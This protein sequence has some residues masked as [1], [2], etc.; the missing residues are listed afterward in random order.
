[1]VDVKIIKIHDPEMT[2]FKERDTFSMDDSRSQ[3]DDDRNDDDD[4][5]R[6]SAGTADVNRT[7]MNDEDGSTFVSWLMIID[8][9]VYDVD[10]LTARPSIILHHADHLGRLVR[11]NLG[12]YGCHLL[13]CRVQFQQISIRV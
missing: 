2:G 11:C 4:L 7:F 3:T 6:S 13:D 1:M 8:L 9:L 12:V 10:C 5:S